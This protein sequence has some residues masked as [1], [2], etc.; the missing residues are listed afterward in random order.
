MSC[1]RGYKIKVVSPYW[2]GKEVINITKKTKEVIE[3]PS[4]EHNKKKKKI[5]VTWWMSWSYYVKKGDLYYNSLGYEYP[6]LERMVKQILTSF[7]PRQ[8]CE[9]QPCITRCSTII[10]GHQPTSD[11]IICN[12]LET[13]ERTIRKL[14]NLPS[15][16]PSRS[17]KHNQSIYA[18]MTPRTMLSQFGSGIVSTRRGIVKMGSGIFK[19]RRESLSPRFR[20]TI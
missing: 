16:I 19:T 10:R 6:S 12:S 8:G 20:K 4:G 18:T 15:Q 17:I 13:M 2:P 5:I 3:K 1:V 9:Y 14:F 7:T 11:S